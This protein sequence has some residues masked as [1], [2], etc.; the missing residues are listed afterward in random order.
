MKIF[1]NLCIILFVLC[2]TGT[3]CPE[4]TSAQSEY[5]TTGQTVRIGYIDYP[6][7]IEQVPGSEEYLGY[8]VEYLRELADYTGWKYEFI[9]GEW[10]EELEM[11]KRGELDF[12]CTAQYTDERAQFFDYGKYPIGFEASVIYVKP[13]KENVFYDDYQAFDKMR[14]GLLKGSYQTT[15]FHQYAAQNGFSYQAVEYEND[16][17]MFE[18]L[19]KGEVDAV[20]AGSLSFKRDLKLVGRFAVDPFY[21]ITGKGLNQDLLND[22]NM[23]VSELKYLRPEFES[24]L[25]HKYYGKGIDL[26]QPLYTRAE[27]EYIKSQPV[28]TIGVLDDL[29]PLSWYNPQTDK[30]EGITCDILDFIAT[31]SGL[32]FEFKRIGNTE[33]PLDVLNNGRVDLVAGVLDFDNMNRNGYVYS[34]PYWRDDFIIAGQ[35]D[36]QFSV[37]HAYKVAMPEN[38]KRL[39]E[40]IRMNFPHYEI[41]KYPSSQASMQAV[42][43]GKADIIIM[44]YF[45]ISSLMQ[46]PVYENLTLW[47]SLSA[48]ENTCIAGLSSV[49]PLL[50]SVIN[51]TIDA[52]DKDFVQSS[53]MRHTVGSRYE[54]TP[55][56]VWYKY[57]STFRISAVLLIACLGLAAYA[58]RQDKLHISVLEE[59]NNQL[60][61][62]ITQAEFA[63]QAK[64]RFLSRMSHELRTP[65]NAIVGMTGLALN[66]PGEIE[67]TTEYLRK[68]KTSSHMLLNIINDILD[69]SAIENEKLKI[70]QEEFNLR[71]LLNDIDSIYTVQCRNKNIGFSITLEDV[72]EE[73]VVGDRARLNQIMMNLLSNSLKF[74]PEYGQITVIVRQTMVK[75][76]QVYLRFIITDTGIGMEDEFKSR[77][78]R[79][80]EQASAATFQQFGGSGLG[81]SITK[82]LV[83]LM[84]GEIKIESEVN[85]GTAITV[86]IPFIIAAHCEET[87]VADYD[88]DD[89]ATEQTF[90]FSGRRILLVDDNE[91]NREIAMELLMMTGAA[92]EYAEDGRQAVDMITSAE[93]GW[94]D[95]VLMDIQMPI[96]NGYEAAQAIRKLNRHSDAA[97]PIIAMTADAFTE[98]VSRALSAGMNDHVAKPIDTDVL[99]STLA[100]YLK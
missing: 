47:P 25:R 21:I 58:F 88:A 61:S 91:L 19:D 100:K 59:K 28:I 18:A 10:S 17:G 5:K 36:K 94:Y 95:A 87:A 56:D 75:E 70:A 52:M 62:A 73:I 76:Q 66:N 68:I 78:F 7:F 30:L 40:L 60:L 16:K 65:L 99:Y 4:R 22:L 3:A 57:K 98:D 97:L 48:T 45:V 41:V 11:L 27:M 26:T 67:K 55:E 37:E 38:Y 90:D 24:E 83:E 85:K 15:M 51:K 74:T 72:T 23:A 86:E 12:I 32:Q 80:F 14:F 34:Q 84:G 92:V 50:M 71:L 29:R 69:M 8:G 93:V 49:N 33:T 43:D 82:N 89:A 63:N 1:K 46:K 81:L 44:N 42:S 54:L 31:K 79:P 64:S 6:G 9:Y 35:R 39:D 20:A 13:D 77:I 2:L 96:M 53:V